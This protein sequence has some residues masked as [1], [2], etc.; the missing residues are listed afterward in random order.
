MKLSIVTTLYNSSETIQEFYRRMTA[1]AKTITDDYEIVFVNDGSPDDSI[2]KAVR[3]FHKDKKVKVINLSRNFGHHKALMTGLSYST[4]EYVFLI[5]SDLEEEPE[6]LKQFWDK[7]FENKEIDVV[8]GVVENRKG[9]L[10]EK[11]SGS[12]FYKLLSFFSD[13]KI[14]EYTAV[15]RL[16]NRNYVQSLTLFKESEIYLPGLWHLTGFNQIPL[17]IKRISKSQSSYT[18]K[19]K[20]QLSVNAIT[21]FSNKPLQIIF[22]TGIIVSGVSFTWLIL[23]IFKKL[24]LT[25]PITGWTSLIVSI[26]LIAGMTFSFLG[27]IGMYLSRIFVESKNRPYVIVKDTYLHENHDT[28]HDT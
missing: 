8:F 5:D 15:T 13:K 9:G 23:L 1:S 12:L 20:I 22:F 19:K 7:Y 17:T 28:Q 10:F 11:I 21:S 4:G 26:W 14:A 18:L 6:N 3:L 24:F 16:M 27:I 25:S 2:R